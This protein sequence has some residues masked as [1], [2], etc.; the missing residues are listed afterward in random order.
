[1]IK[2]AY[3]IRIKINN[4]ERR[5]GRYKDEILGANAANHARVIY[6]LPIL[7]TNIP[8]ISPEEVNAQ[9]L[10]TLPEMCSIVK[11]EMVK[12]VNK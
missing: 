3:T 5:L 12:I 10:S 8:Y 1:M 11:K 9:N 6:G 7:N 2:G 4:V